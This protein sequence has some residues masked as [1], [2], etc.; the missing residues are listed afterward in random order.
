MVK[1]GAKSSL[2]VPAEI[3]GQQVTINFWSTD[4][5]AFPPQAEAMLTGVAQIMTPPR[6]SAQAAAK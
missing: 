6:T 4:A 5:D 2:H 3:K 1:R